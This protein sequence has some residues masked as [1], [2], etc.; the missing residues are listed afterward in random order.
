MLRFGLYALLPF[1]ILAFKEKYKIFIVVGGARVIISISSIAKFKSGF[2]REGENEY[3][4]RLK[5]STFRIELR[6]LGIES[7][8]KA[9]QVALLKEAERFLA[10]IPSLEIL[11]VL[12]ERGSSLNSQQ[13]AQWIRDH[14]NAG[15]KKIT[16]AIGSP[17]GWHQ[18]VIDRAN[19]RLSLSQ[20]TFPF[21]FTRL[22]LIEQIYRAHSILNGAPYHKE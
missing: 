3:L 13:F 2:I 11:V 1:E 6:E 20:L 16:F 15:T 19:L 21:Q 22:I 4:K 9:K 18:S 7:K 14:M 5:S 12:D 8:E 17:A 10:K